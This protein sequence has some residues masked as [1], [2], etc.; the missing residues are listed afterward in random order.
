MNTK[1][2]NIALD[3]NLNA[4]SNTC[5][6]NSSFDI[7]TYYTKNLDII[8]YLKRRLPDFDHYHSKQLLNIVRLFEYRPF[9]NLPELIKSIPL[10]EGDSLLKLYDFGVNDCI[11]EIYWPS[12]G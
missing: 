12:E 2:S 11:C 4:E 3:E 6:D 5:E 10:K 9:K 7:K 8:K 1:I